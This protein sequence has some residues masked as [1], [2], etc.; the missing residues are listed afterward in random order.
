MDFYAVL[1]QV[2]DL[3][4]QRGRVTYNALK[5]QFGLDD[6]CLQD[7]KD[8]IIAAQR[9]AVDEDGKVLVW[10]GDVAAPPPPAAA[11]DRAPLVYTPPHLTDK[12]LAARPALEGERK[13]VTVLFA[14]L[15]DS[16]ELIRG[17]DPEAAQQLLDPAIHIM[18]DAVHR[19]EGTVNQ[20]L[21]DGIMALFGAPIA[22]EDHALRACYAGLA[23]QTAMLPTTEAVRRARGLELRM[24][25]GL[26]SGEVVVRAIGNDLHMDYSAVGETTVLAA[27]ME[28]MATPGSSRLT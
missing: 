3:L 25:V 20:V 28:Q 13:Q 19:F 24:R 18:M 12:I 10:T 4:R 26:N 11:Q 22:H 7:L 27:R 8:E 6:A 16:T 23:M 15:K 1:D 5:R 21:G 14:D 17:L 9:V 2:L